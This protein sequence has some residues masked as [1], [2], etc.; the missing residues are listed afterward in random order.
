MNEPLLKVD[1]LTVSYSTRAAKVSALNQVSFSLAPGQTLGIVGESGSGKTTLALA[2]I[3][4]L[5]DNAEITGGTVTLSGVNLTGLPENEMARHRWTGLSMVFQ[6]AMNAL[7][8]VYTVGDQIAEAILAHG[9]VSRGELADR[10]TELFTMVG[11][12]P[13]LARRYPHEFSGG[14]RQRAVIAMA[15]ACD[16]AVIIADEPTTALDVIVQDQIIRQLRERQKARNSAM[17]YISH[18]VAV[19]AEV[20]DIVGVMYG[21]RMVELGSAER[22]FRTPIHPYTRSLLDS[23]PSILGPRR[24]LTILRGE[25]L[26]LGEVPSG[27]P[28]R[29]RCAR[30]TAECDQEPPVTGSERHHANCWHPLGEG[31]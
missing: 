4:V 6:T 31:S 12:D 13:K 16:P 15:T 2:L 28:F 26:Q 21:G 29:M 8:P 9:R 17:I 20:S 3:R 11:L 5:P 25:P 23:V 24:D 18:D 19:I 30:A 22:V 27:C 7:N 10:I 14:M 1:S